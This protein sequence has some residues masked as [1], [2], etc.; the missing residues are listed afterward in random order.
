[1]ATEALK[2]AHWRLYSPHTCSAVALRSRSELQRW[3]SF[4]YRS[5]SGSFPVSCFLRLRRQRCINYRGSERLMSKM[6]SYEAEK[7]TNDPAAGEMVFEPI[8]EEGVFRFDCS[9]NDRERAYPSL[10]FADPK[11]RETLTVTHKKPN[12]FPTFKLVQQ[13]QI[14]EIKLPAGTSLYGTGEVGGQLERTGKRIFTWNTD[15]WGYGPGTT[16]LYQSHPWVLAVL[17][18]GE[19]IGVLAD[20]TRRC[21]IDLREESTI[22]FVAPAA[23]P[24]ITFGPFT[25][26]TAVLISLSHA[27][28]T[29]F[30]PPKWS[31]GY[32]Q[33]RWSYDS[34]AKVLKVAE[35]FRMKS[36]PCDVIW[37]DIDYMDGFR[38]FT[39]DRERFPDP[40][41]L[42]TDLSNDGF[43]AIWMLDPGIKCEEGYFVYDSGKEND[44]WI[45]QADGRP[46]VGEVWPGPCVFPDFTQEKVRLWWANLVKSFI[47]NGVDGIWNDMNEP[48]IFKTV[49]KTMPESNIHRGDAD[50]GG[51]QSHSHYHNVYG[52]LMARSTYEGMKIAKDKK[53]PFVLT[54]AGFVGSQRYAATWTGDNLSNWDHLHMSLSM[55]VQ[56]GL[57]GQPLSGPDIGGFAGNATPKLFGRWMG[58]GA[59]FP[60]CRGHSESGTA[61]HE[62]WSFGEEC[63]EVCRLALMRRYRLLPHLYTLFFM[64]H[65]TGTPIAAPTF[66]VDPKDPSL[67]K[68]ENS[69]LL[70]PLLIC[71]STTPEKGSHELLQHFP[72][73]IWMRFDFG[74]PHPDLPTLYLQGGS[75]IPVGP[76]LQHVGAANRSDD[77]SLLIALDDTGRAE[78]VLYEDD[79]DGYGFSKG[80]YLLTY[81]VAEL[82]SSV[83]TVKV[84]KV[85]GSW[86]RPERHLNVHLL[87]GGGAK[88]DAQG[89]DGE[90]I[91][92]SMLS[93]T[94][95]CSLIASSEK[96]Y[97]TLLENARSIPDVKDQPDEKGT[98][99]SRT[100]IE[101]RSGEWSLKVVPWIG[102][103]II[104]MSHLPSGTQWLHSRVEI[105]GYEEYSGVE[106]RSAGCIEEYTVINR[107][108]EQSGEDE[109]LILEGDIG[110]GLILCRQIAV[111]KDDTRTFRIDSGIVARNVGAGSGGFSRLVCLRVHPTFSLLHPT[112]VFVTFVSI[113]G[114]KQE[115]WPESGEQLLEGQHRPNG[116][117]ML[118]DKCSGLSLVNKFDV[119]EVNK[120]L[121][122]WGTGTL[123][124]ELWSDERPV[125]RETPLTISHT[126]E[127]RPISVVPSQSA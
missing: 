87:L 59:M 114:T 69:F 70:G 82:Q 106:Y 71:A 28:G 89:T 37:M 54:R 64:A 112:E 100:P 32:H 63:E 105:D 80:E 13:Q 45:Q 88:V 124:M 111:P 35:T 12:Y 58:I 83:V 79:G 8:L 3:R 104:S 52:L 107:N 40:K 125:S 18:N 93:D 119:D 109:A 67:R 16:S 65:T 51:R 36:I 126:Y 42:V 17:P 47:A 101:L 48:A 39:F 98:E 20:T 15:A 90:E 66:F 84:F 61:D 27:I 6:A 19:A 116:E 127:V 62:P 5:C 22:K 102:G 14:V 60:F 50:L 7:V 75:I 96:H 26:P 24:V 95:V 30:M 115:I 31:L 99:L 49:T 43:K 76:P 122:H 110:G 81:Y 85:E 97:K 91:H 121:I 113:D 118:V 56:L 9:G 34:D 86:T 1:M 57:S 92:I 4:K 21:E 117:W 29:I 77:I 108:L 10:S 120:C 2:G 73:G 72:R 103:R 23:Y 74:D 41:S 25:T 44:V 55:V 46:Y 78:G 33:C 123:N 38:C 94:E 11:A 53:R 68:I